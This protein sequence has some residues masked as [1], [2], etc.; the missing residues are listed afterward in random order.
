M[1][2]ISRI[3]MFLAVVKHQ[4]FVGAARAMGLTGPALSKQVQALEDQLGVRLLHRTT[5]HVT[6]TEEGFLYSEKARKALEDLE[7]ARLQIQELKECPTGS[8]KV[9]IPMAFGQQY[10][11]RPIAGFAKKYPHVSVEVDLDDRRI[12]M[13]AEGYDVVVRIGDLKDSSLLIRQLSPCPIILCASATLYNMGKIP[14]TIEN[15]STYPAVT[16]SYLGGQPEWRCR[17]KQGEVF[18]VPLNTNFTTNNSDMMVEACLQG[19]GVAQLPIFSV[20]SYLKSGKLVRVLPEYETYPERG[21]YAVFPQNR[22]LS[23]RVRLFI[24]WLA[25][26]SKEFPW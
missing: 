16:Y 15:L 9:N 12:D 5:R 11:V 4:S 6:L 2:N 18:T 26:C 20:A 13:I 25:K 1:D 10:L 19:L 3:S 21:I 22:H 23:T 17:N 7:E 8:L 24:D 14:D